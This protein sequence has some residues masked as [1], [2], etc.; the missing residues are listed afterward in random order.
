MK[1]HGWSPTVTLYP[2]EFCD[3][4]RGLMTETAIPKNQV[5]M[6]I[7]F[8]LLITVSTVENSD[9]GWLFAVDNGVHF[10]AQQVLAAFLVWEKH[11]GQHSVWEPYLNSVPLEYSTP[12]FCSN[13][14]LELLPSVLLNPIL[15]HRQKVEDT[16]GDLKSVLG[17]QSCKCWHC[18]ESLSSMFQCEQYWWAWS[19]VNTRCVH[20]DDQILSHSLKIQDK[21]C[22]ALAPFLDM[23][24]HSNDVGVQVGLSS[25]RNSYEIQTLVPFAKHTQVFIHYGYHSNLKLYIEYGFIIPLNPHD[26]IPFTFEEILSCVKDAYPLEF[27]C[28]PSKLD[29]LKVHNLTENLSCNF[30]GISFNLKAL[31][32]VLITSESRKDVLTL[33]IYSN[34]F[35]SE[36]SVAICKVGEQ[37]IKQKCSEFESTLKIMEQKKSNGCSRSFEVANDLII[38]YI[39]VLK[40]AEK[41]VMQTTVLPPN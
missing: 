34:N 6:S 38:E 22:L 19:A 25:D 37:L 13:E 1:K 18:S 20:I 26:F 36:E 9:I 21:S 27:N 24:N 8:K 2:V 32:H 10:F 7:P 4:G 16:F 11:L 40:R 35:T 3:T 14:E 33:K 15:I 29:F 17:V 31:I 41:A 23:F 30:E 39:N 5:L 12:L 28:S